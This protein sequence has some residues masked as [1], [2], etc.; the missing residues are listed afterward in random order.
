MKAHTSAKTEKVEEGDERVDSGTGGESEEA[1]E[2]QPQSIT[3][4]T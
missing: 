2:M 1:K 4:A 3:I